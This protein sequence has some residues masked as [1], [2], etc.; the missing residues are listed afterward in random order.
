MEKQDKNNNR[1]KKFERY[2]VP[3]PNCGK[4]I[5]YH[6]TQ[7]PFCKSEVTTEY[8]KPMNP[9]TARRIKLAL[10][11]IGFIIVIILLVFAR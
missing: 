9:D 10:A 1:M 5:L 2:L 8:Y 11:V 3:C 7:C 6:M 4:D